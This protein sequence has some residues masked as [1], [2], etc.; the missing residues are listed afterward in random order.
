MVEPSG[1][2]EL[3][4]VLADGGAVAAAYRVWL[5][6]PHHRMRD[7]H[8]EQLLWA[9]CRARDFTV[10]YQVLARLRWSLRSSRASEVVERLA[11]SSGSLWS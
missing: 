1:L 10:L 9:A 4:D 6:C 11:G 5:A 7:K 8:E 2:G 3:V